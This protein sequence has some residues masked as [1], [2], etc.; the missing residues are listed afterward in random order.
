MTA[1]RTTSR[2]IRATWAAPRPRILAALA[3]TLAVVLVGPLPASA[4]PSFPAAASLGFA[5][6][7]SG[8][9]GSPGSTSPYVPGS[10]QVLNLAV[11]FQ[12]RPPFNG[13]DDSTIDVQ[14]FV[15]DEFTSP[16][17]GTAK[18]L[19]HD[20]ASGSDQPG[21][22]VAG[23]SCSIETSSGHAVVHFSGPQ[24]ASPVTAADSAQFFSL[25]L[26]VPSPAD[27]TTYDGTQGHGGFIVDQKYASSKIFHWIPSGDYIGN[28]PPDSS[29][30]VA[31]GLSRSVGGPGLS[32]QSVPPHRILDSRTTTGS[33]P[34]QLGPSSPRDLTVAGGSTT[35][36][37]DAQA[38]VLNV[39]VTNATTGSFLT[40]YP[41]GQVGIPIASNL[42]FAAGQTIP[43]LVTVKVGLAQ[44]VAILNALGSVDVIADVV[45]Y[46]AP[47]ATRRFNPLDPTRVLDTRTTTGGSQH[48]VT[49]GAPLDFDA[50]AGG[51]PATADSVLMN[52][53]ATGATVNSFLTVYPSGGATPTASN[54]NFGAGQTI[55]NLVSVKLAANGH[56]SFAN[57]EGSVDVVADVV[58][59]YDATKGNLFHVQSPNRI[60][61]SRFANS[62]WAAPLVADQ[63]RLLQVR[64]IGGVRLDAS[65]VVANATVTGSTANSFLTVYPAPVAPVP[66]VSNLN[67]AAGETIPNLVTVKLGAAGQLAFDTNAGATH[68]IFDVVGF[69]AAT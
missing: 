10:T 18:K 58:G 32:F 26:T 15:P 3:F 46:Y 37:L 56:I 19:V 22:T 45:G 64:G 63:P 48:P 60:L 52:V 2:P 12:V 20:A 53:T 68:V 55:A 38:V 11:P 17:C 4:V 66:N 61:D 24:V 49:Q 54:L 40:L 23:W 51:V 35:V 47:T 69:F 31:A 16:V 8:G 33:W 34:G 13:S 29:T 7:P 42:N 9:D 65:A 6:N 28:Q 36:P 5:P 25:T 50:R 57:H 62:A 43:N 44:K 30:S 41:W 39:T 14:V 21:A 27:V 67:F 1:R 59:Y